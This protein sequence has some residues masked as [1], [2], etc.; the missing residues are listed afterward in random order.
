MVELIA[1]NG[2]LVRASDEDAPR[3]LA[4]GYRPVE[5]PKPAPKRR[6]PRKAQKPQEK[7]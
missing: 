5:Q 6:A 4:S 7:Q 1:P 3:M 2:V